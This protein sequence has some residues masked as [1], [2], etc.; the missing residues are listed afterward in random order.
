[1]ISKYH[2]INMSVYLAQT[3]YFSSLFES[4]TLDTPRRANKTFCTIL[5]FYSLTRT[6]HHVRGQY[7]RHTKQHFLR[8]GPMIDQSVQL[9]RWLN[10]GNSKRL[11]VLTNGRGR[12]T[13]QITLIRIVFSKETAVEL[14][15]K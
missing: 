5:S 4:S 3:K 11:F 1:M 14:I 13:H 7:G 9:K 15:H 8:S 6:W 12:G 10:C 2:L